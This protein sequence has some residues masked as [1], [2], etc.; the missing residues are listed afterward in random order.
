MLLA[1]AAICVAVGC[2]V[3]A[4]CREGA[5]FSVAVGS[6]V[7]TAIVSTRSAGAPTK[8]QGTNSGHKFHKYARTG[9]SSSQAQTQA[10]TKSLH[11][12]GKV[13]EDGS[14][15]KSARPRP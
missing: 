13:I 1:A 3:E 8:K 6:W 12:P 11:L 7:S 10:V 9:C 14:T 4:G 5:G 15:A 2:R